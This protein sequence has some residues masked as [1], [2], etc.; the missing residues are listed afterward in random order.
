MLELFLISVGI[1]RLEKVKILDL[2]NNKF[3]DTRF[4]K[5]T[6]D[7]R[8]KVVYSRVKFIRHIQV[9]A[10]I[11]YIKKNAGPPKQIPEPES[12]TENLISSISVESSVPVIIGNQNLVVQRLATVKDIRPYLVCCVLENLDISGDNFKKFINIQV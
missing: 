5:L 6:N 1:L 4:S 10:I 2:S 9:S 11:A 3:K 12:Q 7:K 8:A